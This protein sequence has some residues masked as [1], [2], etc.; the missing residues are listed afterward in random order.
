MTA[1]KKDGLKSFV[2]ER[3]RFKIL[4]LDHVNGLRKTL[5]TIGGIPTVPNEHIFKIKQLIIK[6]LIADST[7]ILLDREAFAELKT[8]L[9]V[10]KGVLMKL[11]DGWTEG[12][13][14]S[15]ITKTFAE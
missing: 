4:A 10:Q 14:G 1:S 13:G 11:D 5:A 15:R 8:L 3:G 2:D 9:P 12:E 7:G 6:T